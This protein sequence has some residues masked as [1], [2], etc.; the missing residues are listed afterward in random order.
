MFEKLSAIRI[1][2][3]FVALGAILGVL[4]IALIGTSLNAKRQLSNALNNVA[5]TGQALANFME[6]DMMH[7]ALNGDVLTALLVTGGEKISDE[8]AVRSDLKE[9]ADTFLKTLSENRKLPLS[10]HIRKDLSEVEGP[11]KAYIESAQ[12]IVA[13]AFEDRKAALGLLPEFMT[14]FKN[15][16]TVNEKVGEDLSAAVTEM[17]RE[18]ARTEDIAMWTLVSIGLIS[19]LLFAATMMAITKSIVQPLRDCRDALDEIAAGNLDVEVHHPA[20]DE[21]GAIARAVAA[22]R[23]VT[24]QVREEAAAREE[25]KAEAE[26]RR[27]EEEAAKREREEEEAR[28]R[29]ERDAQI[30]QQVVGE[31]VAEFERSVSTVVDELIAGAAKL[32]SNARSSS[33]VSLD[34]TQRADT[35]YTVAQNA[36]NNVATV[37]SAAEELTA[38]IGEISRQITESSTLAKQAVGDARQSNEA[39]EGLNQAAQ[40]IGDVVLL[41]QDIA[42]QTNLLAPNATI[43]AARAGEAGKGF[44]V[45]AS[46]V[47]TLAN[48]TSKATEEIASQVQNVQTTTHD[49]VDRIARI[50]ESIGEISDKVNSV[51]AAVDEQS[52]ATAEISRNVQRAAEGTNEVSSNISSV[53]ESAKESGTMA[54]EVLQASQGLAATAERLKAEVSTFIERV[55]AA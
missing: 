21:I 49:T 41:I 53:G 44:A 1:Q 14:A 32:E 27:L 9:H 23:D 16:E 6:G 30:R 33:D 25:A 39:V 37:A 7:D 38:S 42:A 5:V 26:H 2:H 18:A 15:L 29:E 50:T 4:L 34:T 52:A 20:Q 45:V 28:K 54:N 43:E 31:A 35:V 22:Y 12:N 51:A 40:K 55:Q 19:A 10:P 13:R 47:K 36:S 3:K 8:K 46:E 24:L 17:K 11:L 48:Q